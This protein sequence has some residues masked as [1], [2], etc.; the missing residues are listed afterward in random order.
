MK[1]NWDLEEWIAQWEKTRSFKIPDLDLKNQEMLE[2]YRMNEDNPVPFEGPGQQVMHFLNKLG[3]PF[4]A[5]E[6]SWMFGFETPTHTFNRWLKLFDIDSIEKVYNDN[7]FSLQGLGWVVSLC[8]QI[9]QKFILSD[10]PWPRVR[11]PRFKDQR[12]ISTIPNAPNSP[13]EILDMMENPAP[14]IGKIIINASSSRFELRELLVA[15]E[16]S[17]RIGLL[18]KWLFQKPDF[19]FEPEEI[20]GFPTGVFPNHYRNHFLEHWCL[21]PYMQG[22]LPSLKDYPWFEE[23]WG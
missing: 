21:S 16:E 18:K 23:L 6:V 17:N 3:L 5:L 8:Q 11:H 14:F 2:T 10:D 1:F 22:E 20:S 7:D 19:Y 12:L 9:R 13:T 4:T 15:A